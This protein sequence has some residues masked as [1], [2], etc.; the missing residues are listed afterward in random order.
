[1]LKEYRQPLRKLRSATISEMSAPRLQSEAR[2]VF[3]RWRAN[4][5]RVLLATLTLACLIPFRDKAFHMDDP[6]FL[7]AAQHIA[8]HPLDPYGFTVNWYGMPMPMAEVTM[9]PPGA[10]Y[11]LAV[12]GRLAGWS[13]GALHTAFLLPALIAVLGT[14]SLAIRFTRR[15]L[16]AA[17]ATLLTPALLVSA[18]GVM[19]DTSMLALW[20]LATIVWLEGVDREKPAWLAGAALLVALCALTKYFGVALVPLLAVYTV[21]KTRRAGYLL[22]LAIPILILAGYEHHGH[23]LYGHGL[24]SQAVEYPEGDPV[25][26]NTRVTK[27]LVGLSFAGGCALPALTFIPL[28]WSRRGL[29]LGAVLAA[30]GALWMGTFPWQLG[31][32]LCGGLSLAELAVSDLRKRKDADSAFLALWVAGTFVFSAYVNWTVNARSLLPLVPAAGILLARRIDGVDVSLRRQLVPLTL[33]G[34]VSLWVSCADFRLAN[35]ARRAA[36]S[37]SRSGPDLSFEGHWGFQYYMQREGFGSVDTDT[38]KVHPGNAIV[39]PE[40]NTNVED[41][42]DEFIEAKTSVEFETNIGV[43]TNAPSLGAG[44]YSDICGPLPFAFGHVP[45]QKYTVVKLRGSGRLAADQ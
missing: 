37:F 34:G 36:E 15:P 18:S 16:L 35:S 20:M 27:M 41:I 25:S 19:C 8:A 33:A 26:W 3:A 1:M 31:L 12:A 29:L 43:A 39:L 14:Y 2:G 45:P 44:F 9:N 22:Y 30:S 24:L 6:L 28:L 23:D 7:W 21:A 4:H 10:A 11:Y 42:S 40:N 13:E 38:Y 32:F 17:A 5:S